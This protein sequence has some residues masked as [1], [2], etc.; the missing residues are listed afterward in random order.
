ML[1]LV[2]IPE[3]VKHYAPA[4]RELFS[5]RSYEHFQRYLSGLLVSENKTVEG[6]N[7]LFVLD[8]RDQSS[9][10][11]FLTQ[12]GYDEVQLNECRLDLLQQREAS[13]IKASGK[14]RG[15]LSIDDTLL[16]HVGRKFDE[17]AKLYDPVTD[18]YCYAHNLVSLYYSDDMIDYPVYYQ[19]WQPLEVSNVEAALVAA[20][21]RLNPNKVAL[22]QN[23]AKAWRSYLLLRWRTYQYKKPVLQDAYQSKLIIARVLLRRFVERF[24]QERL[25][26][27]FDNWYTDKELCRYIDEE[28]QLPYVG[29]LTGKDRLI[30][31]GSA[32]VNLE[33]FAQQLKAEHLAD[34]SK[35]V[36][37]KTVIPYKGQKITY[38]AYCQTHRIKNF[39]KQ[40][41]VIRHRKDDLSDEPTFLISNRLGWH[42]SGIL[43]IYRHRWPVEV[44]HEEGKAEGLDQYQV[45]DFKAINRHIAFVVVTYSLLQL[46]R[47]DAE[48]LSRLQQDIHLQLEGSLAFWRRVTKAQAFFVLVQWISLALQHGQSI[49]QLMQPFIKAIAY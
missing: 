5:A 26:V 11:R 45:R 24:G 23:D 1:G 30:K 4:F 8:P 48:L 46:A 33:D 27:T 6:I 2:Q 38:Y 7:R 21:V 36:F 9:L 49:E 41:L 31:T 47:H 29:K 34:K 44:Y 35:S 20:G 10:N 12:S 22:R 39:G 14:I 17:I 18:Q 32:Q 37:E 16:S 40:R 28:L 15:C 43:R 42:A 19:L 13:R 25:P 3:L